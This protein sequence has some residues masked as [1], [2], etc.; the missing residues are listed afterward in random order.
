MSDKTEYYL[1]LM[2]IY[3]DEGERVLAQKDYLQASEKFWGAA[4]EMVKAV[5][6]SRDV[7]LKTH[8]D[9]WK[10]VSKLRVELDDPEISRLFTLAGMLHQN[11]YEGHLTPEIVEDLANGVKQ[12][13]EKLRNSG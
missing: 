9:L 8:G 10:F 1:S 11:F 5:A 4:A 7:E 12:F 13:V 6:A 2:Q 3:L